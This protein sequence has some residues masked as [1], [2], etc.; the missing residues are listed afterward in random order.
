M[1]AYL[2]ASFS[3]DKYQ[4]GAHE[5]ARTT[6]CW[7]A[8]IL[9]RLFR[10]CRTVDRCLYVLSRR[11][12]LWRNSWFCL[13]HPCSLLCIV[14]RLPY[15]HVSTVSTKIRVVLVMLRSLY[16]AFDSSPSYFFNRANTPHTCLLIFG[17]PRYAKIGRW[18]DY[19]FG[20]LGYITLSLTSKS[21]LGW[22]VF[23]GSLQPDGDD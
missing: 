5:S 6:F 13:C 18:K 15:Q 10:W 4:D 21:A 12:Q 7:L 1:C 3:D 17:L 19:R 2:T 20:E 8:A 14:Q 16:L 22:L 9:V 11:W 23:G